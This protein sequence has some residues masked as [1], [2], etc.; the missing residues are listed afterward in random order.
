M[1]MYNP[2][3]GRLEY[4]QNQKNMIDQQIASLQ[5]YQVPPININNNMPSTQPNQ[6]PFYNSFDFNGKWVQNE[7]DA[8]GVANN[9]L[10]LILFDKENPIFYM[11]GIDGSFKKFKFSEIVEE[12]QPK[13]VNDERI[14]QLEAKM[15]AILDALG[16]GNINTPQIPNEPPQG[17]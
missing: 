3:Q 11:K 12:E 8:R 5:Q 4:L 13:Q 2:M 10:P 6:S 1:T 9:N 14:N 7:Q 16:Q 17:S 15:S